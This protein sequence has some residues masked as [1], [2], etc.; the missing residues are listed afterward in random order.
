MHLYKKKTDN[1]K[2]KTLLKNLVC[3]IILF[4][5]VL[6]L[7]LGLVDSLQTLLLT[8]TFYKLCISF[9]LLVNDK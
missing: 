3:Y 4:S 2:F 8:I 6:C 1:T 5:I 9:V 7:R